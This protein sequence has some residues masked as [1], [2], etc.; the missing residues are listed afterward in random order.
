[1]S[2]EDRLKVLGLTTL[3]ERR[4]RGDLIYMYK[5]TKGYESIQWENTSVKPERETRRQNLRRESFS[6]QRSNDFCRA[7]NLRHNFYSNRVV[8]DWNKLPQS[9]IS[10][11]SINSFKARLDMKNEKATIVQTG[12]HCQ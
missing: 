8:P 12:R 1:M 9:V 4:K 7:V 5:L 11:P 2:Y 3:E 6:A 10:A